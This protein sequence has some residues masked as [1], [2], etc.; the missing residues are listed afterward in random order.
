ML[1]NEMIENYRKNIE[2]LFKQTQYDRI[3]ALEE[4]LKNMLDEGFKE[5]KISEDEFDI[6]NA[7]LEEQLRK[8]L[9]YSL[10]NSYQIDKNNFC[11]YDNVDIEEKG[12]ER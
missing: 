11:K 10:L 4:K 3:E 6:L 5:K 7:F 12:D 2:I 8:E 9:N 1:N